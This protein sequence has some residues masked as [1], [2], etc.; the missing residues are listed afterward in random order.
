MDNTW[1]K[2]VMIRQSDII[3]PENWSYEKSIKKVKPLVY[4]WK[5]ITIAILTELAIARKA[6]SSPGLRTDLDANAS[7]LTW[8]GYC[9]EI[10]IYHTTANRW[11]SEDP[12]DKRERE[13]N[14]FI[15]RVVKYRPDRSIKVLHGDFR[16]IEIP[17]ES[18]DHIISDPPYPRE[19]LPLWSDLSL[20]ASRV[21]KPGGFV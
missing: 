18:I 1:T 9:K 16:D 14:E 13:V 15:K 10:G 11:L 4:K 6:L 3:V 8:S 5:N 19:Y 17:N 2:D 12:K 21:L 20:M 7:R